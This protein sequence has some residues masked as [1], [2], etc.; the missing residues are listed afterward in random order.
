MIYNYNNALY[1]ETEEPLSIVER[2]ILNEAVSNAKGAFTDLVQKFLGCGRQ[3]SLVLC[4]LDIAT[5]YQK[6]LIKKV[7]DADHEIA[8][9][10]ATDKMTGMIVEIEQTSRW[11]WVKDFTNPRG[12]YWLGPTVTNKVNY[13]E[14]EEYFKIK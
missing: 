4:V 11:R 7:E 8:A 6:A 5:E 12:G 3:L 14:E 1:F 10:L 9:Q 2:E 13:Y